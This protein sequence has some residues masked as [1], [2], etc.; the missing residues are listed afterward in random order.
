MTKGIT[1]V[2]YEPYKGMKKNG[3]KGGAIGVFKGVAGLVG[4]P[5]KGGYEFVS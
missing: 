3:V 5:I 1:G 2:V 4:R